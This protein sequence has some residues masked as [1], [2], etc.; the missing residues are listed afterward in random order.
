M[1]SRWTASA[2]NASTGLHNLDTPEQ[3]QAKT[4]P[5]QSTEDKILKWEVF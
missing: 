3:T 1:L 2:V 4:T 5:I